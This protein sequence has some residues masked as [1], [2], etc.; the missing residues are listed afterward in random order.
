LFLSKH[1]CLRYVSPTLNCAERRFNSEKLFTY[2]DV[3]VCSLCIKRKS[4][5]CF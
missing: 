5:I 4:C 3:M 2:L 1:Q